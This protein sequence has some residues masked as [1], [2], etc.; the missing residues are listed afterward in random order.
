MDTEPSHLD[1]D[2]EVVVCSVADTEPY[3][4][5]R[6]REWWCVVLRNRLFWTEARSDGVCG[7]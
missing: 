2:T 3:L 4:L 6:D 1:R 7:E 5:D